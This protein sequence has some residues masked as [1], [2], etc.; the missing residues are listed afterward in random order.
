MKIPVPLRCALSFVVGLPIAGAAQAASSNSNK[1]G[2]KLDEDI[3]IVNNEI[4]LSSDSV[5]WGYFSKTL[6]PV[7]NITSGSEV[8]V[9]MATHHACDDYDKM[10]LGDAGME[11]IYAWSKEM[12]GEEFRGATGGGDGVHILTG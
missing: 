4:K 1:L 3:A 10:I 12:I 6:A 7:L 11:E 2:R 9:E 8:V 5:H